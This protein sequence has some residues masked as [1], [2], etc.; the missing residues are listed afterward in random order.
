LFR[1]NHL[2][3]T[4]LYTATKWLVCKNHPIDKTLFKAWESE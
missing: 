4:F 2:P 3:E 1:E